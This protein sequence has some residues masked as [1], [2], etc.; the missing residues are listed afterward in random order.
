M[1]NQTTPMDQSTEELSSSRVANT[2]NKKLYYLLLII[3]TGVLGFSIAYFWQ[4]SKIDDVQAQLNS[5]TSEIAVLQDQLSLSNEANASE[6]S[7]STATNP[8]LMPGETDTKRDDNRILISA[9]FKYSLE[10]T[11]VWVEYGETADNLD[12]ETAKITNELGLGDP[13]AVYAHGFSVSIDNSELTPGGIYYYR[14]AATVNGVTE[15]SAIASFT[16][17]K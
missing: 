10:P 11:A 5:A 7:L 1:N 13:D 8:D 6:A 2:N 3:I 14:T 9:V 15:R 17:D 4:K 12:K 16:T